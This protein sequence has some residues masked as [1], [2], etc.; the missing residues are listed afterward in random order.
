MGVTSLSRGVVLSTFHSPTPSLKNH[1]LNPSVMKT[2]PTIVTYT[3]RLFYTKKVY[4]KVRRKWPKSLK[5][6]KATFPKF[7]VYWPKINTTFF[8]IQNIK[9]ESQILV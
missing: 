3:R 6:H 7:N 1:L 4:K 2:Y 9:D 8:Y 5:S